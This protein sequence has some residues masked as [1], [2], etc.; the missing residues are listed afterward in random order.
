MDDIWKRLEDPK[1][2]AALRSGD[3]ALVPKKPMRPLIPA[4]S[5]FIPRE[6]ERRHIPARPLPSLRGAAPPAP[7]GE[8]APEGEPEEEPDRALA[9]LAPPAPLVPRAP[10]VPGRYVPVPLPGFEEFLP[11]PLAPE[12]ESRFPVPAVLAPIIQRAPA[13]S[14]RGGGGRSPLPT[15]PPVFGDH[16]LT[17]APPPE[18]REGGR[19]DR[20]H[21]PVCHMMADLSRLDN[22]PYG[23]DL[24]TQQYGGPGGSSRR[25]DGTI[26]RIDRK[27]GRR[28]SLSYYPAGRPEEAALIQARIRDICAQVL[29]WADAG[30]LIHH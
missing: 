18:G 28:G 8:G 7:P 27:G 1:F 13:P 24:W 5:I 4:G 30:I 29:E 17:G 15:E 2:R 19:T 26:T 11:V 12:P 3:K 25:T 10:A 21:C 22:A 6:N 14:P 23:V 9:P 16:F 20:F